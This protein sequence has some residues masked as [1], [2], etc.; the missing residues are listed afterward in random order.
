M[1]VTFL[2]V[3]RCAFVSVLLGLA[4]TLPARADMTLAIIAP[5]GE[6]VAMTKWGPFASYLSRDLDEKVILRPVTIDTLE[7][8]MTTRAVDFALCN[9]VQSI[10]IHERLGYPYVASLV[11]PTG[12]HFGGVILTNPKAG[13][14]TVA[15]LKGKRVMGFKLSSAGAFLFQAY[16]LRKHG[17]DAPSDFAKYEIVSNQDVIIRAVAEGRADAGF[18]RSGIVESMI[19]EGR[20]NASDI[21]I[22]DQKPGYPQ[23]LTTQLYPEWYL[24]DVRQD[25]VLT[26]RLKQSV[27]ALPAD[28]TAARSAGITGFIDPVDPSGTLEM[29]RTMHVPPFSAEPSNIH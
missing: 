4:L 29:M 13:I 8:L 15:D 3:F 6:A 17:I 24:L 11:L 5:R 9:P 23:A 28:S 25:P 22:L 26:G 1:R 27:Y 10:S 21:S 2:A 16:Y 14:R 20:L 12:T 18:V 7:R 19:M